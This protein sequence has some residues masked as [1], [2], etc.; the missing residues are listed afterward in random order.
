[1]RSTANQGDAVIASI[2]ETPEMRQ[3]VDFSDPYYRTPARFV[4]RKDPNIDDIRPQS[5]EGKQDRG[6]RRHRA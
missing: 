6:G 5:L 3:R 4:A 2:A 1:M